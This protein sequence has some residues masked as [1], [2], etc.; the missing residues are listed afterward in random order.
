VR[1]YAAL[2]QDAVAAGRELQVNS[3]LKGNV[4]KIGDRIRL[5]GRLINVTDGSSLSAGTFDEKFTDVFAVQD[6]ISQKVADALALRLNGE[7]QN[8][9][10][11][12]Y[13]DN[14]EAYQLYI[15]GRYHWGNSFHLT[16]EKLS[17]FFSRLSIWIRTTRWPISG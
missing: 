11:K 14:V 4:Q 17:V 13:T 12:R 3:V 16:S 8:R 6:A 15:T 2:E 7:E 10:K 9:L 5:S 1:K